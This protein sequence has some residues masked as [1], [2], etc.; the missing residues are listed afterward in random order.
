MRDPEENGIGL[1]DDSGLF[2]RGKAPFLMLILVFNTEPFEA[3]KFGA[4][5][6][7]SS[8]EVN[9]KH[10]TNENEK[11]Q[12]LISDKFQYEISAC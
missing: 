11:T 12:L 9:G 4:K 8:P 5:D 3:N 2:T 6:V 1:G 10:D 7:F